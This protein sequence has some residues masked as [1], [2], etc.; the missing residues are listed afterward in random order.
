M[1]RGSQTYEN[2]KDSVTQNS[3]PVSGEHQ[4]NNWKYHLGILQDLPVMDTFVIVDMYI[5]IV[6]S[7]MWTPL[8]KN[9]ILRYMVY[10][11]HILILLLTSPV[12]LH[13]G[14]RGVTTIKKHCG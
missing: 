8:I 5:F 13:G 1:D 4:Q 14:F 10:K 6:M 12:A 2:N 9:Q 11:P 3:K 7:F